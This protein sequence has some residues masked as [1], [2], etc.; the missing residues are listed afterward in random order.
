MATQDGI[1]D[2]EKNPF[3]IGQ[4]AWKDE[5]TRLTRHRKGQLK[6]LFGKT[7]DGIK[8]MPSND[9]KYPAF[10]GVRWGFAEVDENNI[11]RQTEI[12]RN[13]HTYDGYGQFKSDM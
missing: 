1:I 3:A 7:V 8:N 4:Q 9:G 2:D 13:Q 6:D 10:T 11:L 12:W 5:K